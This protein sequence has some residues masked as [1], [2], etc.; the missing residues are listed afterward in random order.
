MHLPA[1]L[2]SAAV[3]ALFAPSVLAVP[4]LEKVQDAAVTLDLTARTVV[5]VP[6]GSQ[7]GKSRLLA[8]QLL[9]GVEPGEMKNTG[10]LWTWRLS[11]PS[12]SSPAAPE[13][14]DKFSWLSRYTGLRSRRQE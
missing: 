1:Y 14:M 12:S 8:L 5:P 10:S 3:L 13:S 6:G 2:S 11:L 9:T 7:L 4:T